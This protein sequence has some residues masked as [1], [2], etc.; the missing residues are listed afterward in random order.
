MY[1]CVCV[2]VRARVS[3][4]V[5]IYT[6]TR[7]HTHADIY[8]KKKKKKEKE[9]KKKEPGPFKVAAGELFSLVRGELEE[10]R[11]TRCVQPSLPPPPPPLLPLLPPEPPPPPEPPLLELSL[12]LSLLQRHKRDFQRLDY[13]SSPFGPFPSPRCNYSSDTKDLQIA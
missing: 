10:R 1:V 12:P 4:C 13:L 5:Y 9:K 7:A 8:I 6:H 11:H 3:L 2:C